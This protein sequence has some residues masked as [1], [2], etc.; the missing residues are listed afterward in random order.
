MLDAGRKQLIKFE[1]LADSSQCVM[2]Q[3]RFSTESIDINLN[4]IGQAKDPEI[5]LDRTHDSFPNLIAGHRGKQIVTL[6]N[7]DN[8]PL[9]INIQVRY[10]FFLYTKQS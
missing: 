4:L 10:C 2:S 7:N 6:I 3:W 8:I 5:L 9:E 1:F